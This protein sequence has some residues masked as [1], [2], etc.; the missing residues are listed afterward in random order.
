[1]S[2]RNQILIGAIA[3]LVGTAAPA[4]IL[5]YSLDRMVE[6]SESIVQGRV[7]GL[8]SRWL[9]GPGSIIVTDVVFAVDEVLTGPITNSQSLNF[10]VV[11]GVVDGLGM[12]QEHQPVF[13]EGEEA[14][15]FLWTQPD[16]KRIAVF[17][18]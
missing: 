17:N 11:G 6:S 1:M 13:R 18:D 8:Q 7:M 3:L 2:Y 5:E 9:D 14:V 12:R 16:E 15:L 10:F 4:V